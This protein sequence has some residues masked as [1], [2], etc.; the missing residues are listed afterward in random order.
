MIP[1]SNAFK[2]A[3]LSPIK[4]LFIKIELY[5]SSMNFIESIEKKVSKNDSGSISVDRSRPVRRN[6]SFSL[7]NKNNEFT[8]NEGAR[9]WLDKRV[10]VLVGLKLKDGTVEYVPQG[11]FILTEPTTSSTPQGNVTTI[12]GQDKAYLYND[13]RG[14]FVN[15]QI[16]EAGVNV[17][18]AIKL[19]AQ[20]EGETL[21]LFDNITET[22][23]YEL[24]FSA[25]DNRWNAMQSLAALA[26]CEIYY[27]VNGFLVLRKIEDLN[28]L[29]NDAAV[30]SFTKGDMFYAGN[31]RKLDEQNMYNDFVTIGGGSETQV[32]SH[33]LTVTETD[34]L[35]QDC[36]YSI[37]RIG[38]ITY[39]HNEG[40]A[41]SLLSTVE[42]CLW[43]NKYELLRHLGYAERISMNSAPIFILD[44]SDIVQ[45]EDNEN[46]TSGRYMVEKFDIPLNPQLITIEAAKETFLIS[47]W[48]FI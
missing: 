36:P 20:T 35:W 44:A 39:F 15:E 46:G 40:N 17:A 12:S 24:T 47:N 9:I 34:P 5:D 21:F 18:T 32:V 48:D 1:H 33:R 38:K 8:W 31:V 10:R 23:P 41:D 14:K 30:W 4:E 19:I 29:Q 22:V 2:Q 26:K 13:R 45:I 3:L 28:Q 43:R 27:D 16:I 25:T 11:V 42:E 7:I 37:E 6:F